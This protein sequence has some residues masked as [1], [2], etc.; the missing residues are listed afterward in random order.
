[1]SGHE[2]LLVMYSLL[3]FQSPI[4]GGPCG[5]EDLKTDMFCLTFT[6]ADHDAWWVCHGGGRGG[7]FCRSYR[8]PRG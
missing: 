4:K 3:R 6:A 1:M 2:F 8:Q 5:D 7:S